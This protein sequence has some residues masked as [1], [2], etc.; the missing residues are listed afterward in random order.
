MKTKIATLTFF[1]TLNFLFS[2]EDAKRFVL[3][4][5]Q[6]AEMTSYANDPEANALVLFESGSV[7][8][9]DEVDGI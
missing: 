7:Q 8:F 6:E 2:Q 1:L 5:R 4:S 3:L 9:V